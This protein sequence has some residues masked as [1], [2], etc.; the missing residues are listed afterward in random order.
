MTVPRVC[1][2]LLSDIK[3]D[4]K[5][6][7]KMQQIS[8]SQGHGAYGRALLLTGCDKF[9]ISDKKSCTTYTG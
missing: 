6:W 1:L 3:Y 5:H 4:H 7:A 9:E 2:L 8:R